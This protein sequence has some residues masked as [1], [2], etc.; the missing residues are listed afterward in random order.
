MKQ[1]SIMKKNKRSQ[2]KYPD[3]E[4]RLN[5][6]TR[7]D[8]YDQDYIDKLSTKEKEWLNKFNREYISGTLDS[9]NPK[10]N[11]HNT[12]K[13]TKDCYDRNNSRN[14]DVLTRAKASN[15]MDD[16]ED[17]VEESINNDYEDKIIN[18]LDQKDIRQ[19][20]E[21]LAGNLDK[22]EVKLEKILVTEIKDKKIPS[23]QKVIKRRK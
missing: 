1:N 5:L 4:G 11:L 10:K 19:S 15:Q 23:N 2:S 20:I 18:E 6:K 14:R 9:V 17:L 8:L 22:D 13:L 16:F 3:L 12:K 7:Y 21:W